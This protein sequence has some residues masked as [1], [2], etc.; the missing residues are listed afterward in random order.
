MITKLGLRNFV[1]EDITNLIESILS[2]LVYIGLRAHVSILE[3]S[4]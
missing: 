3:R 2:D 1:T 4:D